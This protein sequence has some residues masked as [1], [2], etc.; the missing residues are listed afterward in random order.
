MRLEEKQKI[1]EELAEQIDSSGT[2]YLTDF[3]G[4]NVK[5]ITDLR[6]R[7]RAEGIAFRVV[8]HKVHH[9]TR[10]EASVIVDHLASGQVVLRE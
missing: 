2:I 6:A 8:K 9:R 4:L 1:T 10:R 3:T 5:A 7:F